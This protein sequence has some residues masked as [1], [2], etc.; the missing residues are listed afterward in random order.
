MSAL[1]RPK[2]LLLLKEMLEELE[3]PDV[4]LCEDISQGFRLSGWLETTGVFPPC[5]KQP[6]YSRETLLLLA[7]GLN[8]SIVS[9]VECSE[10]SDETAEET[11][12]QTVEEVEKGYVWFDNV[13]APQS[14]VFAKRFGLK[15]SDKVRMID[16]CTI[17][18]LNKAI[19]AVEKYK[20]HSV[21]EI[22]AFLS[23]TLNFMK[24]KGLLVGPLI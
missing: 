9:Q 4:K 2:R 10:T 11:W 13:Q 23:W 3:Y 8:M 18:G 15:Q 17:G 24:Q 20:I 5:V 21:E 7:K 14:F 6:Q 16:D 22:A 12:N 19:G 1:L